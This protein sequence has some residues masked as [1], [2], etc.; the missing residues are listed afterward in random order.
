[1]WKWLDPIECRIRSTQELIGGAAQCGELAPAAQALQ[2][3]IVWR[4][5]SH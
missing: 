4:A 5:K 3:E 1:M 2:Q